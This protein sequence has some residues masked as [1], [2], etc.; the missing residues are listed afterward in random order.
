MSRGG[1][2]R[3]SFFQA[4]VH[5]LP[6]KTEKCIGTGLAKYSLQTNRHLYCRHVKPKRT[7]VHQKIATSDV[8]QGFPS[9]P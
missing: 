8:K 7:F 3:K 5:G 2:Q 6:Q 1:V 4:L 9:P